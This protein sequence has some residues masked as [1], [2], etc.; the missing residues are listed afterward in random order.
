MRELFGS[1]VFFLPMNWILVAL[2]TFSTALALLLL[3]REGLLRS[4]AAWLLASLLI[5]LA[6]GLRRWAFDYETLDYQN[7]LSRW[8]AFYRQNGGFAAMKYPVGNYNIPYLYFLALFSYVPVKDLYLIKWLSVSFDVLL[9]WAS[10]RLTGR[11]TKST[12]RRLACFFAVLFLPTVYLNSAVW[13]QCDS[14]YVALLILG[15][16]LALSG[17]PKTSMICAALAFGFK[18][19]AVFVLPIYVVLW[20]KGKFRW[21]DFLLFPLSYVLLVLPAVLLGRPFLDTVTLYASQTGSIGAGLNYNSPSVF[22]IFWNVQD[23]ATASVIAIVAAFVFLFNM[24]GVA[25]INRGRLSDQAILGMALMFAIG[26]PFLLPHMRERSFYAADILSLILSFSL[27]GYF[28]AAPLVQFAS[29]LGYHAYLKMRY[30]L[31]MRYGSAALI[32][33]FALALICYLAGTHSSKKTKKR[34]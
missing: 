26:I 1:R 33:A 32:V 14:I 6:M 9:A 23:A 3:F 25:W 22:A 2:M 5:L 7:F 10:A 11:F 30:L 34:T 27:P 4:Q 8:A 20:F 29:L 16:E 19:Q 15:I 12:G 13:S 18:L 28:L 24:L 17:R 31:P 21:T